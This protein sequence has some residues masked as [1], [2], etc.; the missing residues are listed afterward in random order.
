M[1]NHLLGHR[2]VVLV[3]GCAEIKGEGQINR[4]KNTYQEALIHAGEGIGESWEVRVK[5][6]GGGGCLMDRTRGMP[7]SFINKIRSRAGLN[8]VPLKILCYSLNLRM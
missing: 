2:Q 4:R 1:L 5:G 6:K 7:L 3:Q 8:C